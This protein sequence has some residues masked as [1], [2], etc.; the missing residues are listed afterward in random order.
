MKQLL[1]IIG[2]VTSALQVS[3][4]QSD[5]LKFNREFIADINL[6]SISKARW[7]DLDNN[8]TLEL[9]TVVQSDTENIANIVRFIPD[10]ANGLIKIDTL[11]PVFPEGPI[12]F[13]DLDNLNGLDVITYDQNEL[14]VF[15]HQ[16]SL[17]YEEKSWLLEDLIIE[18]LQIAD[19]NHNGK[20]EVLINGQRSGENNVII[21][22]SIG[23]DWQI[24]SLDIYAD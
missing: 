16:D 2:L 23:D 1:L 7:L 17:K 5:S 12:V 11:S 15:Y 8:D 22:E 9:V 18:T 14:R 3:Y 4:A 6:D 10:S 20:K 24:K 19:L 21:L 13:S